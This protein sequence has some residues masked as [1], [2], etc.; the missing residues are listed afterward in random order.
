METIVSFALWNQVQQQVRDVD[1]Q[2][3]NEQRAKHDGNVDPGPSPRRKGPRIEQRPSDD[4]DALV[5]SVYS[6]ADLPMRLQDALA[7]QLAEVP[8]P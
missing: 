7:E 5:R 3:E 2:L 1:G 8:A 4:H 6:I